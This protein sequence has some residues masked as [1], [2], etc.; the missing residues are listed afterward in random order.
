MKIL[1]DIEF[2]NDE[3]AVGKWEHFDIV[4][5]IENF[6]PNPSKNTIKDIR[7]KEIYFLPNGQNYWIFEGWTK[8]SLFIHYGGD[9]PILEYKYRIKNFNNTYFMF[10]EISEEDDNYIQV[11]KKVSHKHY[12]ISDFARKDDINIPFEHDAKIIGNW[13]TVA[14]VDKVEDFVC[15]SNENL[16]LYSATFFEDGTCERKYF[17]EDVWKDKWSKGV[18]IDLKKS[19][20]SK[21][22]FKEINGKEFM[23]M[24]WKMGNFV[25]G[26]LEPGYYVFV[27]D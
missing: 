19:I 6:N 14:Y 24:E 11:L 22:F 10:L 5:N 21:Y 16:W 23:F 4:D 2:I 13:K 7:F 8:G 17:D 12:R 25:Y 26:G 9:D 18:F 20:L 1:N 3:I 15:P 27:K